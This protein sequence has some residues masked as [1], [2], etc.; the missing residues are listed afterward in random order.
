MRIVAKNCRQATYL[1]EQTHHRYLLIRQLN[2]P[3]FIIEN[4]YDYLR[5][6]IEAHMYENGFKPESHEDV[7]QYAVRFM[8]DKDQVFFNE[9]RL[10]RHRV[11]YAGAVQP[12]SYAKKVLTFLDKYKNV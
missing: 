5:E 1:R 11:K 8:C 4:V 9:L 2:Y 6:R 7:I 12:Q 3:N 10:N